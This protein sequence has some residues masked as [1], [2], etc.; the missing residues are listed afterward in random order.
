M[1]IEMGAPG[2]PEE[3]YLESKPGNWVAICYK[4][5][6]LPLDFVVENNSIE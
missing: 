2:A 6:G 1:A 5:A 3:V 4:T